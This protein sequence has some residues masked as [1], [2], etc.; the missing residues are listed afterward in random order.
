M[1][2]S[3]KEKLLNHYKLAEGLGFELRYK[4]KIVPHATRISETTKHFTVK[5]I[6]AF[7]LMRQGKTILCEQSFKN[8][9]GIKPDIFDLDERIIYEIETKPQIRTRMK[10]IA[11]AQHP[12][13]EDVI[14]VNLTK[15][16]EDHKEMW[17]YLTT[18][19]TGEFYEENPKKN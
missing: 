12:L 17:K 6:L 11:Q 3:K 4:N 1:M 19:I 10:K 15:V 18:L 5:A 8:F 13:I 16:P 9:K 14:I 7:L 2:A